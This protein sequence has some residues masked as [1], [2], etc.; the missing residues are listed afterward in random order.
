LLKSYIETMNDLEV[1]TWI[2][3]VALLGWDWNQSLPPW[4]TDLDV[5]VSAESIAL[6]ADSHN[7][8]EYRYPMSEGGVSSDL[9][10]GH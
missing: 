8:T 4:D 5:Q 2:V 9:P 1:E 10:A 6:L 3:H 7:M